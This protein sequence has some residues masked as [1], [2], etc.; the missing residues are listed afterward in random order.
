MYVCISLF[1]VNQINSATKM[2]IKNQ[3]P[4]HTDQK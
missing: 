2:T 3:P 4:P 1:R